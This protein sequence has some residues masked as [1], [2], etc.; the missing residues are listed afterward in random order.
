[1]IAVAIHDS[2][3][4]VSATMISTP[5]SYATHHPLSTALPDCH[6]HSRQSYTPSLCNPPCADRTCQV[7]SSRRKHIRCIL[8]PSIPRPEA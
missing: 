6:A 3:E 8:L 1:M 4:S 2:L 5:P 7:A